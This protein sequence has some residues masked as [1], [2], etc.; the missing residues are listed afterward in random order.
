MLNVT[1][2]LCYPDYASLFYRLVSLASRMVLRWLMV[3]NPAAVNLLA[4][5]NDHQTCQMLTLSIITSG[6]LCLNTLS[7]LTLAF[8][9]NLI[10]IMYIHVLMPTVSC[11]LGASDHQQQP[12][13]S[14]PAPSSSASTELQPS[15]PFP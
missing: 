14:T 15:R 8:V 13:P 1:L 10:L 9:L 5:V 4:K 11:L 12:A 2:K 7:T 3:R 6:E